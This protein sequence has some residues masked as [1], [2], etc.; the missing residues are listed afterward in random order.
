MIDNIKNE[1]KK[2]FEYN[3]DAVNPMVLTEKIKDIFVERNLADAGIDKI[4]LIH[5]NLL[6]TVVPNEFFEEENA[7][8]LLDKNIKVLPNDVVEYDEITDYKAVNIYV[9]FVQ[10]KDFLSNQAAEF[11]SQHSLTAFLNKISKAKNNQAKLP[12]FEIYVNIF[13]KEFQIAVFKN[14]QLQLVNQFT[15]D[16]V[17]E[18]LYFLFFVWETLEINDENMH[19][20]LAGIDSDNEIV[21]NIADFTENYSLLPAFAPAKMN[22]FVF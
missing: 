10:L 11:T 7:L 4:S 1:E 17:D 16:T 9:P 20:Y 6:N 13:P 8:S 3:F 14:E 12:L 5:H 2:F 22:N 15:Y 21:K 18:F 19:L